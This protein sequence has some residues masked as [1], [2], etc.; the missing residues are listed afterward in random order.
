M[1]AAAVGSLRTGL[2]RGCQYLLTG[3]PPARRMGTLVT[4]HGSHLVKMS[5]GAHSKPFHFLPTWMKWPTPTCMHDS[6]RYYSD[7]SRQVRI[8][9]APPPLK[10][11]K[12][13]SVAMIGKGRIFRVAY[14]IFKMV[15]LD[16]HVY[17]QD[18]DTRDDRQ[19]VIRGDESEEELGEIIKP[20]D[21]VINPACQYNGETWKPDRREEIYETNTELA[22]RVAQASSKQSKPC[23]LMS[24]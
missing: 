7:S 18:P 13:G 5:P 10:K 8:K 21:A 11:K 4:S 20:H 17:A 6:R 19:H 14:P 1:A 2:R 9:K 15:G 12:L 23:I 24:S 16:P 22:A 3:S